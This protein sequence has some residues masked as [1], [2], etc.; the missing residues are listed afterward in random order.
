MKTCL[1]YLSVVST[2]KE[3]VEA[4]VMAANPILEAFGNAKTIRNDNSSRFGK[5]LELSYDREGCI[6]SSRTHNYLLEK[7]RVH[8][9]N[10]GER[11]FHIFYQ[12]CSAYQIN[13]AALLKGVLYSQYV[14]AG[15]CPSVLDAPDRF[16]ALDLQPADCFNFT[17][18]S[19]F[20]SGNGSET[21]EPSTL[22]ET[23][24][25]M[26][27]L[28]FSDDSIISLFSLCA[29]ILHLG[30][31]T[32]IDQINTDGSELCIV[33]TKDS[34]SGAAL[35]SACSLLKVP[36]EVV[37]KSL[38]CR[39]LLIRGE[40]TVVQLTSVQASEARD[41]FCKTLYSSTFDWIVSN[42]SVTFD[43]TTPVT[44]GRSIGILDIFGFEIFDCNS[45]EQVFPHSTLLC[46]SSFFVALHQL[47]KREIAAA[48]Q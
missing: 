41:T 21:H 16:R 8:R 44:K 45:F 9:Q 46:S 33:D 1:K 14:K 48:F 4:A 30:N 47:R 23:E 10:P 20:R 27:T 26:R 43:A 6:S 37:T 5:F 28:G 17:L 24:I 35:Q 2:S 12:L 15:D 22:F 38:T 31:I 13:E 25:A 3:D 34:C 19:Q 39:V 36:C 42:V 29:T 32:F 40:Q 11:N 7:C 18:Q